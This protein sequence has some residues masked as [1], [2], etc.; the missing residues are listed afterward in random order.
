[1]MGLELIEVWDAVMAFLVWLWAQ[2]QV[3]VLVGH[4]V[5]NV[6][7]AVAASIYAKEFILAKTPEF[8]WRKALPLAMV[9]A[10]FAFFGETIGHGEVAVAVW[11]L[12]ELTL[13]GD[14]FDNLA[15]LGIKLPEGWTKSRAL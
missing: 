2:W 7:V 11:G 6:V 9:Y 4:V 1:M 8:L 5:L 14:T 12:L 3:Q 13:L 15:K 10:G